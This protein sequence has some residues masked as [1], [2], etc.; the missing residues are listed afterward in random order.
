MQNFQ[1]WLDRVG[2]A[3]FEDDFDTYSSAV[4]RPFVLITAT[5]TMVSATPEDLRDGFVQ[6][7]DMLRSQGATDMVR[8][9]FGVQPIG[10]QLLVGRYETH[11]LRGATRLFDPY[12]SS[13]TL[14][15]S[16]GEWRAACISN[17][18]TNSRWPIHLP[19]IDAGPQPET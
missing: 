10:S 15:L 19:R 13:M 4:E 2:R 18:M 6:F 14:R 3:F 1:S 17:S 8:L 11:I 12:I 5:A 7:R 9:A 16:G